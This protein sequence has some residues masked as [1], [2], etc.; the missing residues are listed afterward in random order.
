MTKSGSTD[1]IKFNWWKGL[2]N[3]FSHHNEILRGDLLQG[4]LVSC[5]VYMP[6]LI[7]KK[8]TEQNLGAKCSIISLCD[9]P[10][11]KPKLLNYLYS[12]EINQKNKLKKCKH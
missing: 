11:I 4:R 10:Y 5:G 8:K 3:I 9:F 1:R 2:E 12:I 6:G 7:T